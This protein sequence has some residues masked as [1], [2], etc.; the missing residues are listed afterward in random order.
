MAAANLIV[1]ERAIDAQSLIAFADLVVSAGGTMNR[2]AVALGTPV[3]TIFSRSHG[4]GRRGADRRRAACSRSAI[5][6]ELALRKR[7]RGARRAQPAR[8][9]ALG[10]R[11]ARGCRGRRVA[12]TGL[13]VDGHRA[14]HDYRRRLRLPRR[15]RDRLAAGS[16]TPSGSPAGSARS[17]CPNERSL[18][19]RAD[20]EARRPGDLGR[21]RGGGLDLFLPWRRRDPRDPDRRCGDRRG[22][23]DRRRLRPAGAAQAARPGRRGADP[24]PRRRHASTTSRCRSSAASNLRRR[25]RR[26]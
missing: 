23:G 19:D 5:P 22:R 16:A 10:R 15:R 4:G 18:H 13:L 3:Y 12:W 8:P 17:T 6:A 1:P 14:W 20:A 9:R 24:G 25:A 11:R 21:D 7:R 26:S 2:E